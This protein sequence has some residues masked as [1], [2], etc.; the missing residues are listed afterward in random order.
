MKVFVDTS[1][2]F[3]ALVRNDRR[4]SAAEQTFRKLVALDVKLHS[5]SYVLLETVALL[6]AR[7]GLESAR[8]V[9]HIVRPCLEVTWIDDDLHT[10]AFER[11]ELRSSRHLSLVDCASF[12]VMEDQGISLAFTLDRHFETEGFQTAMSPQDLDSEHR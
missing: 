7:V 6:Q 2:L 11:L 4:H 12:V 5:T 9:E 1:A 3:A 8:Q 10:R